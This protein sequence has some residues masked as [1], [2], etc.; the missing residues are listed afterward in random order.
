MAIRWAWRPTVLE[1]ELELSEPFKF[2]FRAETGAV[3]VVLDLG[4]P[5]VDE[6]AIR[7]PAPLRKSLKQA[8]VKSI[9]CLWGRKIH[10]NRT[11]R[12]EKFVRN[13]DFLHFSS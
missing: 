4:D 1:P 5:E 8:Q 6:K 12:V 2:P 10:P 9:T 7:L 11:L 13:L 3:Q